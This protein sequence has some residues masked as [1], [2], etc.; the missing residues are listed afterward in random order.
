MNLKPIISA[1]SHV[2]EPPDCYSARIDAKYK[3]RAPQLVHDEKRGDIFIIEG[4]K[5]RIPMS[6]VSAAGKKPEELSPVGAVFE[7]LHQGGWEPHARIK[8]QEEDNIAAEIIYPSVGME[9]CNIP[10][11]GLKQACMDAYN[12]WLTEFCDPYPHRLIGAAQTAVATPD[13]GIA[14]LRRIKELGF[15]AVMLPGMPGV[16][17]YF[18]PM[19]DEFFAA[20]VDLDLIP[21][22]HILTSGENLKQGFRGTR[23]NSFMSIVRGNQDLM[24]MFVFD[25]IFMRHPQLKLVSVE[26][27]GG[28]IPHF[29]YRM[30]HTYK[31]HR[32]WLRGRELEKHPSEYVREHVYFTFQDDY[33]AFQFKDHMNIKRMMWANDYPHSDSTWPLSQDVLHEHTK[34]MTDDEINLV[35]HDNVAELYK[36]DTSA[37]KAA[38]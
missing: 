3:D 21:S 15:R 12:L 14:D 25:G 2:T 7:K 23:I 4:S 18:D 33:T 1:D 37:L 16:E 17:D 22:F 5:T 13:S 35:V 26:A 20:L 11:L 28:W 24:S 31:R 30:D 38:A 34:G 8:A 32:H 10:D 9:L 6:L 27:D 29:A 36:L 19:Y